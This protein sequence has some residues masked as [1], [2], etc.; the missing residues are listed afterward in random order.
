[1]K[2]ALCYSRERLPS[3]P[4]SR[5]IAS[6]NLSSLR[7]LAFSVAT[8]LSAV[9]NRPKESAV[10]AKPVSTGG[11]P[12]R[13]I[14]VFTTLIQN[15]IHTPTIMFNLISLFIVHSMKAEVTQNNNSSTTNP[16]ARYAGAT[17]DLLLKKYFRATR[18]TAAKLSN[19]PITPKNNTAIPA[20]SEALLSMLRAVIKATIKPIAIAKIIEH[21]KLISVDLSV[22]MCLVIVQANNTTN[23][24]WFDPMKSALCYSRRKTTIAAERLYFCVRNGNRCTPLAINTDITTSNYFFVGYLK[25]SLIK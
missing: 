20:P 6:L 12:S 19:I 25:L 11:R 14:N 5:A 22:S 9:V 2:S 7:F 16:I 21:T 24:S 3:P 23:L 17:N 13:F 8:I 10:I 4:K 18:Y 1:M 15:I